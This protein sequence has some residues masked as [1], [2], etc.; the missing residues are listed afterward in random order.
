M[1]KVIFLSIVLGCA[2]SSSLWCAQVV[3]CGSAYGNRAATQAGVLIL[4][5]RVEI[6]GD[7]LSNK[8]LEGASEAVQS[9]FHAVLSRAFEENSYT[10][11]FVP[12]AMAQWEEAPPNDGAIKTL[13]DDYDSLLPSDRYSRPDCKRML[14]TS[15]QVDLKKVMGSN[16]FDAIVLARARGEVRSTTGAITRAGVAVARGIGE[17]SSDKSLYFSI[18]VVDGGTGLPLFYCKSSASG[19]YMGAPDSRLSVPI[20]NCLKRYFSRASKS[21]H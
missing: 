19:N 1:G 12:A 11:R 16:E 9:G 2:M 3:V 7:G 6:F 17:A 5:P 18:G 4:R 10:L 15:L 13:Q 14:K 21:S 8:V 20:Q